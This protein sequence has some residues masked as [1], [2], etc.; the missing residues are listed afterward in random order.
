M[1]NC[2]VL[3]K[4][5]T[6]NKTKHLLVLYELKMFKKFGAAYFRGKNYFEEIRKII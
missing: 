3:I 4:K 1:L 5:I 2:Q 6:S